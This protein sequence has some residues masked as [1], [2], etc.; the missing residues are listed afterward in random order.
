MEKIL[1]SGRILF[2][3]CMAALGAE[4]LV[5][6][7]VQEKVLPVFP[8][9]PPHPV[10][11]Y[12]AG[13]F[14]IAAGLAIA[15]GFRVRLASILLAIFL[16]VCELHVQSHRAA[17]TPLDLG[18]RTTVF[19]VAALCAAAL[20]LAKMVS[21]RGES[22]ERASVLDRMLLSGRYLFALALLVF[23]IAHFLV[24]PHV[25][26]LI[27][28]WIPIRLIWAYF[29]G[30]CFVVAG[31]SIAIRW[32]DSVCAALLGVMF[33]LWFVVLHLP[34]IL[35][36]ESAYQLNEWSSL[37][38]ALGLCGASWIIALDSLRNGEP[39]LSEPELDEA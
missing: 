19:E 25:A 32:R 29:T 36:H 39:G 8:W 17:Y 3:L 38:V 18:V 14:L 16:L 9:L 1:G 22:A 11:V 28:A 6:A 7:H 21:D 20:T 23:G 31:V 26:K 37:F 4:N 10:L 2:A 27:P 33:L 13:L 35:S 5:C 24:G 34:R 12:L 15:V 30:V